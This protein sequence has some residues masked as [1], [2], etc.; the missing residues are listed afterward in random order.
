MD[1]MPVPPGAE[2]SLVFF[3]Y[4]LIV[5]DASI[6][7]ERRFDYPVTN[8]NMLVAQ[9][10]LRVNSEQ[11]LS[12]GSE[13]FQGRQY[14]FYVAQNPGPDTPLVVEF[15]PVPSADGVGAEEMVSTSDQPVAGASAR[16]NQ[17]LLLWIGFGLAALAVLGAVIYPLATQRLASTPGSTQDLASNPKARRLL[18]ELADLEET[19][20]AGQIDEASYERQR[21]ELYEEL[22]S[23]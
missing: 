5:A 3:S 9:P 4:H 14:E 15:V 8:L 2:T 11:L 1:T 20:E 10:G 12:M 22:R 23:R 16:G 19:F 6:P 13:A 18:A 21:A 17:R 7:L